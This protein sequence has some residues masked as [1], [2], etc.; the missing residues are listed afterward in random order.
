MTGRKGDYMKIRD[1]WNRIISGFRKSVRAEKDLKE[2]EPVMILEPL[3][4]P[5]P[6]P[7]RKTSDETITAMAEQAA[8]NGQAVRNEDAFEDDDAI[9]IYHA[10]END[11]VDWDEI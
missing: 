5:E 3:K 11:E 9:G 7:E 2:Q 1:L 8:G 4:A 6:E 10:D